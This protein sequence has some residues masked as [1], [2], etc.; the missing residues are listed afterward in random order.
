ME[1]EQVKETVTAFLLPLLH[2]HLL[3]VSR[4]R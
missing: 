1:E 2:C 3:R 4:L